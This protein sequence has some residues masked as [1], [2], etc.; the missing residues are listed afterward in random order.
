MSAVAIPLVVVTGMIQTLELVDDL[1]DLTATSW[2]R[3]L[4]VKI[5]L[6]VV[7]LSVAGV[8]RWLVVHA[9]GTSLWR[10]V[11]T[12]G[13]LGLGVIG[14]AAALVALPP[15]AA[16]QSEVFATTITEAGLLA[17]VT[18]TPGRVGANEIHIVVTPPGSS[19]QP[20]DRRHRPDAA[21]EPRH[22]DD[23]RGRDDRR[24]EPLHGSDHAAVRRELDPRAVGRDVA[25]CDD[26]AEDDGA[27]P[28]D[29]VTPDRIDRRRSSR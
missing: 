20:V 5:A 2:G 21:A 19:L 28:V 29:V 24:P 7:A 18:L 23:S 17:D 22:P 8:S 15:T 16:A 9:G 26:P 10:T 14:L 3:V 25:R 11:A 4:L 27:D 6:V 12:E 13:A 1:G